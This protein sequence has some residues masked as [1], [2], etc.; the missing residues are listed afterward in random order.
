MKKQVFLKI[1]IFRN[2]A[3][4]SGKHLRSETPSDLTCNF[5][6]KRLQQKCFPVKD[7]TVPF[8]TEQLL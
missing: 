2:F 1:S 6:K 8:P 7:L 4:F 5:I 3:N